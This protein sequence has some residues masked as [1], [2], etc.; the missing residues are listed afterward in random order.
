MN[1]YFYCYSKNLHLFLGAFNYRYISKAI[2]PIT[3]QLYWQYE[4]SEK[5]D[6]LIEEWNDLKIQYL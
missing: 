5:L 1:N 6:A 3:R 4:K 2:H